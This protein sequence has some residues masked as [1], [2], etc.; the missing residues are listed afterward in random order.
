MSILKYWLSS[1]LFLVVLTG[2]STDNSRYIDETIIMTSIQI[3]PADVSVP[4]GTT[5]VYTAIAYYSDGNS[6]DVSLE[7]NWKS[8]DSSI[9]KFSNTVVNYAEALVVGNTTIVATLNEIVSNSAKVEVT[10]VS[11]QSISVTPVDTTVANGID[12]RYKAIGIYSDNTSYDLT[13]FATWNSTDENIATING[14][15]AKAGL[16]QTLSSGNIT[17]SADF[18]GTTGLADLN[19]T[20]ASITSIQ[21]TPAN[22]SVPK[23]TT[24]TYKATAYYTDNTSHDVTSQVIWNSV[25][26]TIATIE[27]LG[28]N[29]GYAEALNQGTT[30][31]TASLSGVTSNIANVEVTN[32]TLKR[33]NINPILKSVAK[34][35]EVNYE[36]IGIYSDDTSVD[37]TLFATWKSSDTS[38]ATIEG[39][40]AISGIAYTLSTGT[41]DITATFES[42]TSNTATLEVTNATISSI[43]ITPADTSVPKGTIGTYTAIA[44]YTDSTSEDVTRAATWISGDDTTV[45]IVP[46]GDTAGDAL[47]MTVGNTTITASFD[48]ATSNIATVEVTTATLVSIQVDPANHVT[49]LGVNVVYTATGIYSDNTSIDLTEQASWNSTDK[50]TAVIQIDIDGYVWAE[51]ISVGT[52]DITAAFDGVT[53]NTAA[54]EVTAATISSIQITPADTSIPKGT[55]GTYTAIAYYSDDTS[56]DITRQATWISGD[57]TVVAIVPTGDTAGDSLARTV[58]N[59]TITAS[60]DGATSNTATIEVTELVLSSIEIVAHDTT[61]PIG[62]IVHFIGLAHYGTDDNGDTKIIV[63]TGDWSSEDTS[64]A[65][66]D[67]GKIVAVGVGT[68][69]IVLDYEGKRDTQ[70]ITV[71]KPL[72]TSI[73]ITPETYSIS[74]D[75]VVHYLAIASYD[76][77]ETKDVTRDV[78]W[79]SSDEGVATV[80]NHIFAHGIATGLNTGNTNITVTYEGVQVGNTAVLNVIAPSITLDSIVVTPADHTITVYSYLDY[81]AIGHYSDGHTE[82]LTRDVSWLSSNIGVATIGGIEGVIDSENIAFSIS[83]GSTTISA[84]LKSIVGSTTLTVS[85]DCGN[86]KP[87]TIEITPDNNPTIMS[88]GEV[89]Q[90]HLIGHWSNGCDRDITFDP[91][92]VWRTDEED[93]VSM[94][95]K[96]GEAVAKK[97]GSTVINAKYRGG[98]DSA[99]VEVQ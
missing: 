19:V 68:T 92:A 33:I 71:T 51:T 44:Y 65:T 62:T 86:S 41:T 27:S 78:V 16:A 3:T 18:N 85:G 21:I 23:G 31:I 91:A 70:S 48:G 8:S 73:L 2:C 89:K 45:A 87:A 35:V 83:E 74:I 37:L 5:G 25:D 84:T 13:L 63:K 30:T 20:D 10:G 42:I 57:D 97:T 66:V 72:I 93:I 9:V 11:L 36:A 47:A 75:R 64:I 17:I 77:G 80:A 24:G 58:G 46:T 28:T 81:T 95:S 82:D 7:V 38:I 79:H 22:V 61:F 96:G 29:A 54:L 49:P 53:S 90:F 39:R 40:G 14:T 69:T 6:K 55:T 32:A 26:E 56:E 99:A 43:Q 60:F 34:G 4:V 67:K 98:T 88:L 12:V 50:G 15:G 1:L 52:T 76:D 94:R 59:T